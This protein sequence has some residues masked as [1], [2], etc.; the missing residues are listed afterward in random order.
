MYYVAVHIA[1]KFL[2]KLRPVKLTAPKLYAVAKRGIALMA[3]GQQLFH[4]SLCLYGDA[5][6][7]GVA[8]CGY[9]YQRL[10]ERAGTE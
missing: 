9:F 6:Q 5:L 7:V 3:G 4:I 2:C 8:V 1:C 10:G